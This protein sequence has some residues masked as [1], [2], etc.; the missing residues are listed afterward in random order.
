MKLKK[1]SFYWELVTKKDYLVTSDMGQNELV[2]FFGQS[3][4][5]LYRLEVFSF[6]LVP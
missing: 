6:L 1:I 2:L 3:F 4:W 5:T